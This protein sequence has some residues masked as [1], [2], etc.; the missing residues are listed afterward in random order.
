MNEHWPRWIDP[1]G[2]ANLREVAPNLYVG[3]LLGFHKGLQHGILWTLMLDVAGLS[4]SSALHQLK[5]H[6]DED[7]GFETW[8]VRL[9]D[10]ESIPSC[11]LD[12]LY[13]LVTTHLKRGPVIIQC[14]MGLSR[15]ASVAYAMLRTIF[16]LDSAEALRRV[17]TPGLEMYPLK[18][19]LESAMRWALEMRIR[20]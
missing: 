11:V 12:E 20:R 16:G 14:Q 19:T 17:Q 10:G 1:K 7:L 18:P 15:S 3:G 13:L 6:R 4:D 2:S 9:E 5:R 8:S